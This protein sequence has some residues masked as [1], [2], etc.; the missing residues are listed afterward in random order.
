MNN[1]HADGAVG[2]TCLLFTRRI[3][4]LVFLVVSLLSFCAG[5][6]F[7][8][9]PA[10]ANPAQAAAK[11]PF[12][13]SAAPAVTKAS[14]K[15][16]PQK[17]AVA[18]KRR[19]QVYARSLM[20]AEE[21]EALNDRGISS[22]FGDRAISRKKTRMH[23]GIDIPGPKDSKVLAYNDG[24]VI[25]AGVRNGYGKTVVIRQLDGREALYA[26]MNK[27]VVSV[28]DKIK[29]GDHIGHVGRTG[30]ATGYHLHFEII[31]D[32][33][34]LDPALHVWHGSELVLGPNDL[35]PDAASQT[36]VAEPNNKRAPVSLY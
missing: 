36:Q 26:H 27:F 18:P 23:K 6:L 8:P 14:A 22:G 1:T 16:A 13:P 21:R 20:P 30:R 33:E 10:Q 12:K 28:G 2:S 5:D 4:P 11:A 25:F 19:R 34:N 15:K 35:D 3:L 17:T 32:G 7:L 31:D 9:A 24:E 29:R